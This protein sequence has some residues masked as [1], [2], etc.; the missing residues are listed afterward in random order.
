MNAIERIGIENVQEV[1]ETAKTVAVVGFSA[2]AE[3]P[4]H[5]VPEYLH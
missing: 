4:A 3:K 5:Y 1:L 2:S